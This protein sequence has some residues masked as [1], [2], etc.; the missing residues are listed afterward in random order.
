MV[1]I[2]HATSKVLNK[3]QFGQSADGQINRDPFIIEVRYSYT[4]IHI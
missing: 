2:A 3:I 1:L 4:C